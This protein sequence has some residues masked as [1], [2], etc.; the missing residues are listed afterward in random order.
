MRNRSESRGSNSARTESGECHLTTSDPDALLQALAAGQHGVVAR[1]QLLGAGISRRR[2][3]YYLKKGWLA[4]LHLG[5]YQAGPVAAPRQRE[6]AA[7]LAC[8]EGT[9]LSHRSAAALWE[10]LPHPGPAF[11]VAVSAM[12]N[13]RGRRSGIRIHRVSSL[14]A[15]EVSSLD[16]LRLTNPA[17]TLLDLASVLTARDLER[18]LARADREHLL[19]RGQL[20]QLLLRYS[21]RPG[22][23]VLRTLLTS[24]D[25]PVLTRSEAEER[26][27]A[28]IREGGLHPPEMNVL[29]Q[30]FEVDAFW[31]AERLVVEIDG[32]A[33]HSARA[34]F[35]RDRLRDGVLAAAGLR[36][37]RITW[38]Q[39]ARE[40]TTLLVRLT[41]ALAASGVP[42]RAPRLRR[43]I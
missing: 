18:A 31:R 23:A 41:Q 22:G 32:Y 37:V 2:I 8:G 27:L 26:F 34:A 39:L 28:L 10:L 29:V 21:R 30:G 7:L 11:P 19:D 15:D 16:S 24:Q 3:D 12:R 17:R 14:G 42:Q 38:H 25:G 4:P 1:R 5:I 6:M 35:E 9:A 13:L 36:V 20:E 33:F 40:P 43:S